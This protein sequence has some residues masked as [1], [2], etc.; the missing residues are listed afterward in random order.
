MSLLSHSLISRCCL[1]RFCKFVVWSV[2]K[3]SVYQYLDN[4]F[5]G[6][7]LLGRLSDWPPRLWGWKSPIGSLDGRSVGLGWLAHSQACWILTRGWTSC[8]TVWWSWYPWYRKYYECRE[9]GLMVSR[10]RC[11]RRP[12][13]L[14]T[15]IL[16]WEAQ[17]RWVGE[18]VFM[19]GFREGKYH[20][21]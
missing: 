10:G 17:C 14:S 19:K 2:D 7:F 5:Y 12:E 11:H 21:W 18:L 6:I 3:Y 9:G 4:G 16:T 13:M 8:Q 1:W 20:D 15:R